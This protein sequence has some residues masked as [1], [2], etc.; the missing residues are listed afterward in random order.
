VVFMGRTAIGF[1]RMDSF[2]AHSKTRSLSSC[3]S[4]QEHDASVNSAATVALFAVTR[5]YFQ[6]LVLLL[7]ANRGQ[8]L[9][10]NPFSNT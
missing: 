9:P 1:T 7:L 4:R 3:F 2:C 6:A 5:K 10:Q 8:T